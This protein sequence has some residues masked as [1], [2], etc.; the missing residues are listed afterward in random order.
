VKVVGRGDPT[1]RGIE[2]LPGTADV[3]MNREALT[4]TAMRY[5]RPAVSDTE[6]LIV[7]ITT[8]SPTSHRATLLL[9]SK[10][11]ELPSYNPNCTPM[12][13][14]TAALL[15][16]AMANWV[17]VALVAAVKLLVYTIP[18]AMLVPSAWR[19]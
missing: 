7:V 19:A 8:W 6:V 14:N 4:V 10:L 11:P 12:A 13:P 15:R 17:T 16:T 3:A 5:A 2:G 9:P 18:G 1:E